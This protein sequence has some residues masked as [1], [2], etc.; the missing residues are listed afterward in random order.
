MTEK[1]NHEE[2]GSKSIF[3]DPEWNP[4]GLAPPGFKNVAYNPATFT[5]KQSSLQRH[6]LG[7]NADLPEEK[8]E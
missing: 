4:K 7:I 3:Y 8:K 5:R 1:P 2:L 6:M